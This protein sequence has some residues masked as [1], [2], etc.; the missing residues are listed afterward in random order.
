MSN[1]FENENE[2]LYSHTSPRKSYQW[3]LWQSC[4][5]LCKFCYL[6]NGNR[7]TAKSRQLASLASLKANLRNLDYSKYNTISI[8]GG[9]FFQGQLQDPEVNESFFDLI[10]ILCSLYKNKKIGCIWFTATLATGNQDDLYKMLDK[11]DESGVRPVPDYPYSSGV[12]LCTSWDVE[13]RFPS[14]NNKKNWEFHMDK[15]KESYPWVS[16]N[17]SIVL[18]DKFCDMYLQN[19]FT[20]QEFAKRFSTSLAFTHPKIF[21]LDTKKSYRE[22]VLKINGNAQETNEFLNSIK[23]KDKESI[24]FNFYPTRNK[25]RR[26]LIKFAKQ[27]PQLFDRLFNVDLMPDEIHRNYNEANDNDTYENDKDAGTV[28]STFI[29][30]ITNPNCSLEPY[31]KKHVINFATYADSNACM[32]CDR[33]AI[34]ESVNAAR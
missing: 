14:E 18:S 34:W 3:E 7:H 8:I 10:N 20:P 13:G 4:N 27:D 5:N 25:F 28:S 2:L 19:E 11:L 15:I 24:G 30:S 9:E 29:D 6:G 21:A 22:K 23:A 26:F 33:N 1:S 17:T 31:N 16:R 32:I 12:V